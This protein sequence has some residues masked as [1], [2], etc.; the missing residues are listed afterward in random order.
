MKRR[1]KILFAT[2]IPITITLVSKYKLRVESLPNEAHRISP[3]PKS[4]LIKH[5]KVYEGSLR[6]AIGTL[7]L[8]NNQVWEAIAELG[9]VSGFS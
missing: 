2:Q 9:F 1:T 4:S 3:T 7:L 8:A 5:N 6:S